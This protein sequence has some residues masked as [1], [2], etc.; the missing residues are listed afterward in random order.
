MNRTLVYYVHDIT[1]KTHDI[2]LSNFILPPSLLKLLSV[3]N[4]GDDYK[5]VINKS[6]IKQV[7][8]TSETTGFD[9]PGELAFCRV[10]VYSYFE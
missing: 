8:L 7:N 4:V 1:I 3:H 6:L 5:Q 10:A 9:S 2:P